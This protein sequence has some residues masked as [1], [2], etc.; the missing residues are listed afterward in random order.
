MTAGHGAVASADAVATRAGLAMLQAGGNAVDAAIAANAVLGVTS[1]FLCGIGGDLFALVYAD[2]EVHG[3]NAS[4]RAGSGASAE[5]LRADG[6]T[7]MPFRHDIRTV[8]V[9][10]CVDGWVA[11]HDRFGSMPLTGVLAPAIGL[12]ADGFEA[13]A[14]LVSV[15]GR[16]DQAPALAETIEQATSARGVVRRPG[17]ARALVAIAESGRAGFYE[18]E[19]GSGL[20]ELGEGWYQ[21]ADLTEPAAEWVSAL[22]VPALG[23]RLWTVPPNSQGYLILAACAAADAIGVPDDPD[24]PDWAHLLIEISKA[25]ACD[26]PDVLSDTADGPCLIEAAQQR[27]AGVRQD[28]AARIGTPTATGDTTYLCAADSDGMGVSLIQSNASGFGSWLA[29]PSTG[30]PLHNRGIGFSL[31]PGHPAEIGPGRRPPH[32]LAPVLLTRDGP[33]SAGHQ[34]LAGLAGTMGGDGQPQ[35]MLQLLARLLRSGIA[36]QAAVDAPRWILEGHQTGF[37]TWTSGRQPRVALEPGTPPS[38]YAD[39]TRRGHDIHRP[40]P[41]AGMF[42]H[43]QAILVDRGAGRPRY[44]AAADPRTVIGSAAVIGG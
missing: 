31:A 2:G 8:T 10:G 34:V 25:V 37:D 9:P 39:L 19:F 21:T 7:E 12:A 24:H 16:T 36:P 17:L 41:D 18:G 4:G 32:T 38:W 14:P 11:L 42:G 5:K 33:L 28:R 23:T 3:L 20:L 22:S 27:A 29:E 6:F 40:A 13:G 26:R 35:I 1:P 15:C 43:A 44:A 30:V